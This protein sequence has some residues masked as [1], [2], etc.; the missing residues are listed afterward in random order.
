MRIIQEAVMPMD[1]QFRIRCDREWKKAV[2][3]VSKSQKIKFADWVRQTLGT[4]AID[5]HRENKLPV[6]RALLDLTV[7]EVSSAEP[8]P[9][10]DS[11][12]IPYKAKVDTS[13]G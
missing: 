13:K 11:K 8:E 12:P 2:G 5:W 3:R 10:D 4:M 6:P 1:D 7:N 9:S